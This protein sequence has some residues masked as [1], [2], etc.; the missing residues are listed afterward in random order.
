MKLSE[1]FDHLTFGE[2]AQVS[3]GGI[4]STGIQAANYER[5]VAHVNMGLT[6]LYKRF[7]LREGQ[8]TLAR[9]AGVS[10]YVLNSKY[11][12]SAKGTKNTRYITDTADNPF[13]DDI[14]KIERVLTADGMELGLNGEAG[15]VAMFQPGALGVS[16]HRRYQVPS[17]YTRSYNTLYIPGNVPGDTFTVVYRASHPALEY[18]TGYFDP[19]R[20]EVDLP[21]SH[22]EALLYYIAS[23]IMNPIGMTEQF[24]EG[25]NYASKYEQECQRLELADLQIDTGEDTYPL[26]RNGWV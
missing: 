12:V 1:I 17:V 20:I 11:A 22:L 19:S 16:P 4:D 3:L 15:R 7:L 13:E 23:R 8:L 18:S 6:A 21:P 2:L 14:L 25:N 24:H 26:E 9:Q 10:T 5:M